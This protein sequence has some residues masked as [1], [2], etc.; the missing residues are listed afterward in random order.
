MTSGTTGGKP[1]TYIPQSSSV[2]WHSS[3]V[4]VLGLV[5]LAPALSHPCG[6][7]S[8]AHFRSKPFLVAF[9]LIDAVIEG[10]DASGVLSHDE[11]RSTRAWIVELL[12][13]AEIPSRR[14]RERASCGGLR[15][16]GEL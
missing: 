16:H 10:A 7:G 14:G 11:F 15:E 1:L 5:Y 13:L 12:N 9:P 8:M 2:A 6:V 3:H 4:C